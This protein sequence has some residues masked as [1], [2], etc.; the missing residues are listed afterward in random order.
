MFAPGFWLTRLTTPSSPGRTGGRLGEEGRGDEGFL[1]RPTAFR[2]NSATS[3]FS[4]AW[5]ALRT[6]IM[7]PAW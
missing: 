6:Y 1:Y 7:W 3:C 5:S 4:F 2:M